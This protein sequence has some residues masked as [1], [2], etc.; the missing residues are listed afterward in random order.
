MPPQN[1][2]SSLADSLSVKTT[3]FVILFIVVISV[4]VW[5][6][7]RRDGDGADRDAPGSAPGGFGDPGRTVRLKDRTAAVKAT[8]V[9]L[10]G[11]AGSGGPSFEIFGTTAIGRARA[12]ADL[13]LQAG[14]LESPISRLHCTIL[15]EDGAFFLRDEQS[16]NG[17]RLNGIRLAPKER[18]PLKDGDIVQLADSERGGVS[19]QFH[20]PDDAGKIVP[21]S[22]GVIPR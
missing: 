19:L 11:T 16:A 22:A 2:L 12:D 21:A 18:N 17:T 1:F 20:I 3:I 4:G 6:V 8:L 14:R 15:E 13:V 9:D 7:S 5:L 10:T